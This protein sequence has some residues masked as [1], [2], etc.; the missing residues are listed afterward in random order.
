MGH[1]EETQVFS[2]DAEPDAVPV[3][4]TALRCAAPDCMIQVLATW[5]EDETMAPSIA[6]LF[7]IFRKEHLRHPG[8]QESLPMWA[9]MPAGLAP[10]SGSTRFDKVA[11]QEEIRTPPPPV[12]VQAPQQE[13]RPRDPD[14]PTIGD[15]YL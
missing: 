10:D 12:P 14:R 15:Y 1:V 2:N 4:T 9:P 13:E 11:I 7:D 8:F 5:R 6:P 3:C